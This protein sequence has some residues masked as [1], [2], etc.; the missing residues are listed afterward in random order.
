MTD[1][2]CCGRTVSFDADVCPNCGEQFPW[3]AAPSSPTPAEKPSGA[4]FVELVVGMLVSL[5]FGGGI[6]VLGPCLTL[7]ILRDSHKLI[8]P[9]TFNPRVD[10]F[11]AGTLIVFSVAAFVVSGFCIRNVFGS[12]SFAFHYACFV[13]FVRAIFFAVL[14]ILGVG[15]GGALIV[16]IFMFLRHSANK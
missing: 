10:P 14:W 16:Y 2:R 1:C 3:G 7:T 11:A 9:I 12:H 5:I 4:G 8:D 15:L 6:F 13:A